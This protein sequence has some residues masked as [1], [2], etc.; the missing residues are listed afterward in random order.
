[1][2][3]EMMLSEVH[4]G[5]GRDVALLCSSLTLIII[6]PSITWNRSLFLIT[7][8]FHQEASGRT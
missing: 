1:M 3:I 4:G 6:Y 2:F 8:S 7:Q 5:R